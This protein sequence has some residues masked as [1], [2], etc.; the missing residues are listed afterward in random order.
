MKA[1]SIAEALM[2]NRKQL[3]A[4]LDVGTGTSKPQHE[5]TIKDDVEIQ[6]SVQR[7]KTKKRDRTGSPG[8]RRR[9]GLEKGIKE[10]ANT[11]RKVVAKGTNGTLDPESE[12]WFSC[13]FDMRALAISKKVTCYH[14][15]NESMKVLVYTRDAKRLTFRLTDIR[16]LPQDLV[17]LYV[18]GNHFN[19]VVASG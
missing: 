7:Q 4:V 2:E 3:A 9:K 13:E 6:P 8:E 12:A 19:S 5:T 14:I 11:I 18:G 17:T 1:I 15:E 10:R 16:P